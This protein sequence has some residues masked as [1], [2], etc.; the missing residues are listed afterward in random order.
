[1]FRVLPISLAIS[2]LFAAI[3][4]QPKS[5][6]AEKGSQSNPKPDNLWTRSQGAD[7]PRML[8]PNYDSVSSE[9]GILKDWPEQGL[10]VVWA[11]RTGTGYGNG[12]V[13][14]GRLLQ[15]DRY[16]DEEVLVC[17]HAETGQLLWKQAQP[18]EYFDAYG[19]NN[20]PRCSPIVDEEHVYTYGVTGRLTCYSL[21]DGQ[22][23]WTRD[24]N[25]EF[26]VVPNFFGVG[27]T[28]L[29]Y[30]DQI[31]AMVG[32]SKPDGREQEL[33]TVNDVPRAHPNRC[34]MVAFDKRTGET[35]HQVGD[36]LASYAAPV[37]RNIGGQDVCIAFMREGLLT[38]N[39]ADGS[40]ERFLPWRASS[41]E[42]V[43]AGI[44]IVLKD[45][46]LVGEA[47][48]IGGFMAELQ[49][50]GLKRV[51]TDESS[52]RS[53]QF[54]PHWTN[55]LVSN[56]L[57]F[58]SSGRNQ[59]DTDL[60][61]VQ[62]DA[63][64][65][66]V[67]AETKWAVRNRNRMTGMVIDEHLLLLGENGDLQLVRPTEE[68]LDIVAEM[69]LTQFTDPVTGRPVLNTPFWAPPVV[70]HGLLYVRAA[71]HMVCLELIPE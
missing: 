4:L 5:L 59:P 60:R 64:N 23:V 29:V 3:L 54:R 36:Y 11:T 26:W 61:C 52:R 18:V 50:D 70:S 47:Y 68:K 27:A 57:V 14:Q 53:Q 28:P 12:V 37:V 71:N 69:D 44:P 39:P 49:A 63:L 42:S 8:G 13:S 22:I 48:E 62:F 55:P 33:L 40:D 45:K 25:R 6:L 20:G 41:L 43:N 9:T 38:F 56:D 7:W 15:F 35:K 32:G 65:D 24:L 30:K 31:W 34:G 58:I 46:I 51:W 10:R 66:S 17:L 19:Y 67:S 1:M 2:S 21:T 16:G